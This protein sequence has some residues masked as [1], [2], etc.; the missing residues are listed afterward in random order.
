M[1]TN[2]SRRRFNQ[3]MVAAAVA[4]QGTSLLGAEQSVRR[5]LAGAASP[6]A[7]AETAPPN[8]LFIMT[9]QQRFDTIAALGNHDIYT[10]NLDRLVR[11]GV[12][13]TQA[14]SPCPVCVPARYS[15]R[16]GCEPPTTRTFANAR[17]TPANGQAATMA[18]RCGDYLAQAMRQ[19]GYRTFGIGKFHTGPWN[20]DLGFD[21][22]LHSEELIRHDEYG[23]W[24]TKEHPSF[25]YVE[26]FMGERS[27]MYYMPQRSPL[28]A[29][30]TVESWA[31]DRATE[32]I[33]AKDT[34]PYFGFVSFVGPHPPFAPPI[35]FNRLYDPDRMP[36]PI[37]GRL[38]VDHM[39]EQIPAM[40]HAV[41]ADDISDSHARVL[42]ARYYGFI[43]YID[44]CVGKILDAVEARGDAANT[45]ICFFSD[46]GDHLG[47]HSA[48]QKESFFEQSCH[49][50]FLVSWPARLPAGAQRDELICLT[51]LFALA[52]A[53]GGKMQLRE[54]SDVLGLLAGT[55]QPRQRVVG[56]HGVPGSSRFKIMVRQG[57]WK[58]IHMANGGREQL[59]QVVEDPHELKNLADERR[60]MLRELRQ[61]A[62]EACRQPGAADALAGGDL[63]S[64]PFEPRPRRRIL[65]SDSPL[66]T[67]FPDNPRDGLTAYRA[68]KPVRPAGATKPRE[69]EPA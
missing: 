22:H 61:V 5:T 54:G 33:G 41:F 63:K 18:G 55:A 32:Q 65:Q 45:L 39:D 28:P 64:F 62:I 52:T 60:D 11:R 21:V 23:T 51:D 8:V 4:S 43:T 2:L 42:K 53:A 3:A 67:G 49:I 35:P 38:E 30:L 25:A 47:D 1:E 40:N 34:R 50:P 24:M 14:Y 69:G 19:L 16:T 46:H 7:E 27:E 10:P 36:S 9:D 58:Y 6:K 56:Y 15:I 59:F 13:F 31:A 12:A 29:E 68:G 44:D 66:S 57:P 26:G 48:W 37:R 20:E 17:P